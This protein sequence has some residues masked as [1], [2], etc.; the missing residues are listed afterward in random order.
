MDSQHTDPRPS[1]SRRRFVTSSASTAAIA[2]AVSC[3]PAAAPPA[4]AP[5]AAP[6]SASATPT[7]AWE[8]TWADLVAAAKAEGALSVLT[9]TG[10]SYR[11]GVGAFQATYPEIKVEHEGPASMGPF[12]QKIIQERAAGVFSRDVAQISTPTAL[13]VLKPEKVWA[14]IKGTLVRPDILED[15]NWVGGFDFGWLDTDR[16]LAYG[17]QLDRYAGL[18][19]NTDLVPD[20]AIKS[21][22]DL[23]DLKWKGKFIFGE[24][25]SY[26]PSYRIATALRLNRG[27]DIVKRLYVDQQPA[28]ARD[29]RQVAEGVVRGQYAF[30]IFAAEFLAEFRSQGVGRNVKEI[31][32]VPELFT[33]QELPIFMFD[34]APHPNAAKLFVNWFLSQPGQQAWSKAVNVNSRRTDVPPVNPETVVR[35]GEETRYPRTNH[36][37]L[38]PKLVES[39]AML[40]KLMGG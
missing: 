1:V 33:V 12:S 17:F 14:P 25:W 34:K 28:V 35:L 20:G 26:G 23:L 13:S 27:D 8:K 2:L 7:A 3:V 19:R 40:K 32:E 30:G 24:P 4:T 38:L 37:D 6:S 21:L 36:E 5:P 22:D 29:I 10:N 11:E 39:Q 16:Q 9:L 31:Y 15:K 18:F